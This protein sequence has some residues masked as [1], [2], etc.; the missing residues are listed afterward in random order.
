MGLLFRAI[1]VDALESDAERLERVNRLLEALPDGRPAPEGLAPVELL[2]LRPSR[3][4]SELA[5]GL[6]ALLP[7]GLRRIVRGLG[8]GRAAAAEFLAYLLFHP[9]YTGPAAELGY[10]DVRDR[11]PRIERFFE[12]MSRRRTDP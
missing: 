6:D 10:D 5:T 7:P 11:W 8:G 1:F 4:L 9:A 3:N 2:A 12:R